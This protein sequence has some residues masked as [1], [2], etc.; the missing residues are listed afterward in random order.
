[1]ALAQQQAAPLLNLVAV[2]GEEGIDF[3]AA[4]GALTAS[5][6]QLIQSAPG[7]VGLKQCV[8]QIIQ[9]YSLV[10]LGQALL[11]TG[12]AESAVQALAAACAAVPERS[13]ALSKGQLTP[14]TMLHASSSLVVTH[15][16]SREGVRLASLSW[17]GRF[18]REA[19]HFYAIALGVARGPEAAADATAA[20]VARGV[21]QDPLQRPLDH[22][23]PS[24]RR[25]P[26]WDPAELPA[27]CLLERSFDTILAE[28]NALISGSPET[29]SS[30]DA[31]APTRAQFRQ[32][33][34]R[35]VAAGEWSDVQLY[36]G[37]RR[38]EVH[39]QIC[40]KT[41][42]LLASRPE[43]NTVV[44]GSHFFSRLSPGTHLSAHCGPS[45]FRLRCHLGLI[46]PD[47]CMIRVGE[48]VRAWRAGECLVFDD[49]FEHEVWH[50]G[51]SDRVV[52]IADMWHPHVKL[53]S[54]V[55][56]LLN[57][58]QRSALECAQI[59]E[60]MPLLQRVYSTG[61]TV[62]RGRARNP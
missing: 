42:F 44:F 30:T 18:A 32:Y 20:A 36:A 3:A 56:P 37:C 25:H 47:N 19:A 60:H 41:A 51:T 5:E 8:E 58:E 33:D 22:L 31:V 4:A 49:S 10:E 27:A 28:L 9:R 40:P 50:N 61:R 23:D 55:L 62:C 7:R 52:L 6:I 35:V 48:E 39:C 34:S 53:E 17:A 1:M 12:Q 57:D 26:F 59:Q 46:V 24:L 16:S 13:S 38:D 45:N 11:M 21:W 54:H 29:R 2:G 43:F 14:P 15:G